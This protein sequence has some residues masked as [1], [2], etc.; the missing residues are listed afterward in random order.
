MELEDVIW[1][2]ESLTESTMKALNDSQSSISLPN[3]EVTQRLK[4][5]LQNQMA[6][7]I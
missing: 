5:L 4:A 7:D 2:M 1:H 3:V 6:F